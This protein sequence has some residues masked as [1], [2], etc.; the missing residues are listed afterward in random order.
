MEKILT[1]ELANALAE[2]LWIMGL[3]TDSELLKVKDENKKLIFQNN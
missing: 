3:L 2:K 1:L